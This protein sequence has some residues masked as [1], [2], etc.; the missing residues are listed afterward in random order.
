[1]CTLGRYWSGHCM[2]TNE[3]I[4]GRPNTTA[5]EKSPLHGLIPARYARLHEAVQPQSVTH[6]VRTFVTYVVRTFR[7]LPYFGE[8]S[9][10]G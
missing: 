3:E 4:S 2:K 1:V 9:S 8:N 5:Y 7:R 10:P 6:V